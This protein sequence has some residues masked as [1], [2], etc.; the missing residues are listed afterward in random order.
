MKNGTCC[1]A[2]R[3]GKGYSIYESQ[4][5]FGS[6]DRPPGCRYAGQED[7]VH[8]VLYSWSEVAQPVNR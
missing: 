6:Y 8:L 5:V 3:V 4:N 2:F 7:N 1:F